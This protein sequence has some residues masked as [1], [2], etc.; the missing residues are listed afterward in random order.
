MEYRFLVLLDVLF[1]Q[2]NFNGQQN[3]W[4]GVPVFHSFLFA[5]QAI[6]DILPL[7][8]RRR[9]SYIP[10]D[11]TFR[12]VSQDIFRSLSYISRP[13]MAKIKKI[14]ISCTNHQTSPIRTHDNAVRVSR[15]WLS[16]VCR[17]FNFHRDSFVQFI[18]NTR[19]G[20]NMSPKPDA[21]DR[22]KPWS[23]LNARAGQFRRL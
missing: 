6:V 4:Y 22:I 15:R 16:S 14:N 23:S 10:V 21:L 11:M 7:T 3:R 2:I 12:W 5:Y 9:R 20:L 18:Q 1:M 13:L 19:E 8:F 17:P